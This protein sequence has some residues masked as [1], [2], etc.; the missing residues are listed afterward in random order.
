MTEENE[1][2]VVVSE[3]EDNVRRVR[4]TVE[5]K[6]ENTELEQE[7]QA[8][9]PV[10]KASVQDILK[11]KEEL[12]KKKKA[13]EDMTVMVVEQQDRSVNIGVVG[14]GQCGSKLAEEFHNL[15]Y[16]AVAI[17]TA[18]QDLKH[19]AIP[20]GSKLFLDYALGGAA[21]DLETGNAA[22]EEYSEAISD[23]V[24][25]HL[26]EC[27]VLMLTTSGGGGT[28]SGSAETMVKL[29]AQL[30]KPLSVIFVL[31]L[32][33]EDALSKH[34]AIVTLSKLAKM[35]KDD[36]I[37]SLAVVD[38]AKIELM[39]PSRSMADFW[40]LANNAIVE[41]LHLFNKLSANPSPYTSLDPMDFSRLFIGT[42]DC[43]LY[44]VVEVENYLEDEAIAEAML[45]SVENGL[46]A[47]DFDLG[48]TRS[49]GIII[50]GTKSVLEKVP[51]TNIEYGFAMV[52]KICNEGTR[53]FRGVYE[54]PGKENVLRVY[55]FFSGLGLPE[56]RVKELKAEAE[57]H[58]EVLKNKEESRA[59]TM[60][61]DIG[62]TQTVSAA[63][64]LHKKITQKHSAM[65]KLTNNAKR[66]IDKRRK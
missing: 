26:G 35:A 20:E 34:N 41:P 58:M 49:A 54:V 23:H 28:G 48:Q 13:E 59:T 51:A 60:T 56:E 40:K 63:D 66:V 32:S 50:T 30:G 57:R 6:Q 11:E 38:N 19:I 17:N 27:D 21:K 45:T 53:V 31:P 15:G 52:S 10:K 36:V 8:K 39:F 16:P 46:L 29:L 18:M 5:V 25:T 2:K 64:A 44:G 12:K 3:T 65:G 61:I 7:L 62:K 9:P 14:V 33:S 37:N 4:S 1:N 42:G 55:S 43:A 22:A 24:Q 47:S